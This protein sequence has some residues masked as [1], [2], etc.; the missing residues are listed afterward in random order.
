M[1]GLVAITQPTGGGCSG[2]ANASAPTA[3]PNGPLG[4]KMIVQYFESNGFSPN[5][6][7]GIVG[8]MVQESGLDPHMAGGGLVQNI[9]SQYALQVAYDQQHGLDPSSAQGQLAFLVDYVKRQPW[10]SKLNNAPTPQDAALWFQDNYEQCA[11][12]GARGT[13]Q[14]GGGL[15]YPQ[16]RMDAAAA[17]LQ[18]AG[19]TVSAGTPVSLGGG[20]IHAAYGSGM[21]VTNPIPGFSRGRDDMGVDGCSTPGKPI[22]APAPSK[23]AE[24]MPNWYAGQPLLLFKFD[25]PLSGT[26]DGDQYWFLAEQVT[27][28]TTQ[29]GATFGT[30]TPVAHYASS[31]TCVEI[32][33]GSPTSSGR[34][35]AQEKGDSGAANPPA[36][37]LTTWGESFRKFF[38][39]T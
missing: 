9:G 1:V 21:G 11:G 12:A 25:P 18:V 14:V 32:G 33:W 23:L 22:L 30:G 8:N 31:G 16:H 17:A 24:I 4:A 26:F 36:G 20:C 2:V 3:L 37:A 13:N 10:F 34:T 35:L 38:R 39:I 5:A 27:P 28:V 15:C 6:A 19:G 29:I 7:A